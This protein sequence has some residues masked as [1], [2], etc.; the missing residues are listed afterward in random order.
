MGWACFVT[1]TLSLHWWSLICVT[2]RKVSQYLSPIL[3][4]TIEKEILELTFVWECRSLNIPQLFILKFHLIE[5]SLKSQNLVFLEVIMRSEKVDD[6][7]LLFKLIIRC[8]QQ[9]LYQWWN[10]W[11]YIIL[12]FILW[13]WH[14][15]QMVSHLWLFH[16][17]FMSRHLSKL[18]IILLSLR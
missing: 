14:L 6:L 5:R 16:V 3:I 8:Q 2:I 10:I 9:V 15:I 7:L 13:L 11:L 18:L 12:I 17:Q 1:S 4:D